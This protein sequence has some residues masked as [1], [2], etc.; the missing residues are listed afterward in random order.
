MHGHGCV[1]RRR[2]R[3]GAGGAGGA[4]EERLPHI[5]VEVAHDDE[6]VE[7]HARRRLV[8]RLMGSGGRSMDG[9]MDG[10]IDGWMIER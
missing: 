10:W 7:A 1:S 4:G 9:W 3:E 2:V 5:P 8:H 6:L